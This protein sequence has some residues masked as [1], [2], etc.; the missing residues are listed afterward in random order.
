MNY[1]FKNYSEDLIF[2][3]SLRFLKNNYHTAFDH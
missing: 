3:F 2:N 1:P